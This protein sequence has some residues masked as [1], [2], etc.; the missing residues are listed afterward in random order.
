MTLV[1]V[2]FFGVYIKMLQN[3]RDEL[4]NNKYQEDAKLLQEGVAT[5]IQA[6]QRAT[7]GLA[8]TLAK[9]DKNLAYYMKQGTIPPSYYKHLIQAYK[10][11]TFY[12][13]IW[14]HIIDKNGRSLYRSWT[15]KHGDNVL[16]KRKDLQ[17]FFNNRHAELSLSVG[18]YD[19]SIKSMIPVYYRK[20]FVGAVE[21]ISHFNSIAKSM[22]VAHI[23]SVVL[24]TKAYSAQLEHPFSEKFV[25]GYY[26][27]NVAAKQKFLQHI[28]HHGVEHYFKEGYFIENGYFVVTKQLREGHE[29]LGTYVMFK[30]LS[31]IS[32]GATDALLYKW[33]IFGII[34]ILIFI[35]VTN[36]ALMYVVRKQ[37]KFYKSIIDKSRNIVIVSDKTKAVEVNHVF[38]EYFTQYE[39]L[40]DFHKEHDCIC[41]FFVSE[42]GYL[43]KVMDGKRWVDYVYENQKISH[44]AKIKIG[45]QIYYFLVNVSKIE[46]DASLYS[47]IFSDITQEENYKETLETITIT[48]SLTNIGNRRYYNLKIEENIAQA[49]R[50]KFPLS[51]IMIDIDHF[52]KINDEHGHAVG[53]DVLV[54]YTKLINSMT[55]K[56][57]V[58]CRLGGEEFVIIVPYTDIQQAQQLAQKIRRRVEQH[59]VIL[60]VTMSFGVAQYVIGEDADRLLSRADK[61]LYQAKEQGRNQV[62]VAE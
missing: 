60:P 57:D 58:F 43:K 55:R 4:V 34:G 48:D 2:L 17:Q 31:S 29:L 61:A 18:K 39:T 59:K 10:K 23:D 22:E 5:L 11:H 19:L 41:D 9:N 56:G 47:I 45:E 24:T 46:E 53:D 62:V 42:D 7:L 37:R 3:T 35:V 54:E 50:Y 8:V 32:I 44:K 6:K 21:I 12:K 51:V 40:G 13:N 27:A 36:I 26:V 25:D 1:F 28:Q 16:Q 49:Q 33:F 52:K 14:I 15:Q 30:K 38:F 20:Q